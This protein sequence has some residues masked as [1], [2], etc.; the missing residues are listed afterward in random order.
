MYVEK[1]NR[2]EQFHSFGQI[3]IAE[4][5]AALLPDLSSDGSVCR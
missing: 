2:S 4:A 1:G 5:T 3:L